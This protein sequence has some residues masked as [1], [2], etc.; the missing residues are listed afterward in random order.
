MPI[1]KNLTPRKR[2]VSSG[3][4]A[5]FLIGLAVPA[6]AIAHFIVL[7][8]IADKADGTTPDDVH[9][10]SVNEL[11]NVI[12]GSA[13]DI[14]IMNGGGDK[15]TIWHTKIIC[16]NGTEFPGSSWR[17]PWY[18]EDGIVEAGQMKLFTFV[19]DDHPAAYGAGSLQLVVAFHVG[20]DPNVSFDKT[21]EIA[22]SGGTDGGNV[23]LSKINELA[24][25]ISG[26]AI[27]I[28]VKNGLAE[29][30]TIAA[31]KIRCMNGTQFPCSSWRIPPWYPEDGVICPGTARTFNF[32]ADSHPAAYGAGTIQLVISFFIGDVPSDTFDKTITI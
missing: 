17:T 28:N 24:N 13:I 7:P 8:M 11:A 6:A 18:P 23:V 31:T 12:S 14:S 16:A 2:A 25:V 3:I 26:S 1:Q 27:D 4:A 10:I 21:I 5:I 29:R 19:F 22:I 32:V 30:I 9:L 20:S 15:I